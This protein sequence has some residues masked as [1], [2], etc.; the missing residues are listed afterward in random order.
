MLCVGILLA[1]TI[2]LQHNL[3]LK[4][5]QS[6]LFLVLALCSVSFGKR[7][8]VTGSLIF[9]VSTIIINLFSPAGEVILR[10]GGVPIT[11]GSLSVGLSKATTL[12]SLLYL[13][14]FCVRPSVR[15]P[16]RMGAFVSDTFGY[17]NQLLARRE[18]MGRNRIVQ[19]LD[20]L[21]ESVYGCGT[22]AKPSEYPRKGK[23][24]VAGVAVLIGVL[25]MNWAAVFFPFSSLLQAG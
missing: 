11:R 15:L 20:Q 2:I 25:I 1:P 23:N 22:D 6:A 21:F 16:G 24:S 12:A 4:A 18:R 5:V 8:L 19:R 17:L 10:V 14:R 3:V 7:R 9:V 13:S